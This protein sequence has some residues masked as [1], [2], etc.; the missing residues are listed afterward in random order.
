MLADSLN[1]ISRYLNFAARRHELLFVR[2]ATRRLSAAT[3]LLIYRE[4]TPVAEVSVSS[5]RFDV[6]FNAPSQE[7]ASIAIM[8]LLPRQYYKTSFR[9]L[10]HAKVIF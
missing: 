7:E 8:S 6:T 1:K 10:Q 2:H 5:G 3:G 4:V 9:L